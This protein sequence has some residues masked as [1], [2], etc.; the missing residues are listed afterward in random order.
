MLFKIIKSS[1]SI[2]RLSN[3]I[4]LNN[5]FLTTT[6]N[7]LSFSYQQKTETGKKVKMQQGK[8]TIDKIYGL[9]DLNA[10]IFR[11]HIPPPRYVHPKI[12]RPISWTPP[13]SVPATIV[14]VLH[15]RVSL[16]G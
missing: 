13:V 15:L 12:N 1:R 14:L 7:H 6:F 10:V 11:E 3:R 4:K 9:N 8:S 5:N 16:G 2:I